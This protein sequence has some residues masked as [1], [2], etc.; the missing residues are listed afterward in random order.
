[1]DKTLKD[2]YKRFRSLKTRTAQDAYSK[3]KLWEASG[4]STWEIRTVKN[5]LYNPRTE[6]V[7]WVENISN[8][9][10]FVGF[11][12][13]L[14]T[15]INHKGWYADDM[16]DAIYRGVVYRLPARKG[17]QR[18][19]IGYADPDNDDCALM[20]FST[21]YDDE[22]EAAW[23]ANKFAERKAEKDR[24]Y[25]EAWSAGS[26]YANLLEDEAVARKAVLELCAAIK[27][28][29]AENF[30]SILC[31]TLRGRIR[32]ELRAIKKARE[33]RADLKDNFDGTCQR[34]IWGA[35]NDGAGQEVIA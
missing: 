22:I 24:E 13:V 6:G 7:C 34:E 31:D 14:A 25:S 15:R 28:H 8:G 23:A 16:Q 21:I 35:F 30:A 2:A 27:P 10:N 18:L 20:D 19:V 17:K 11:A 33:E 32:A 12:D 9:L 29:K 3:A 1:M 4:K 26:Q 5:V